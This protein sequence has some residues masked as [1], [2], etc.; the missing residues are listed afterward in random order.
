MAHAV[1]GSPP[2]ASPIGPQRFGEPPGLGHALV[3]GKTVYLMP[4]TSANQPAPPLPPNAHSSGSSAPC[5][6][7][8][9]QGGNG[10]NGQSS[11]CVP[12][13]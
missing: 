6:P 10:N 2:V 7:A 11:S 1:A 13:R 5:P 12:P 9:G 3:N 8:Q 4:G